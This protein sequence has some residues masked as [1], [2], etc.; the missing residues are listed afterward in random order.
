VHQHGLIKLGDPPAPDCLYGVSKVFG[1]DLGRYYSRFYGIKIVSL[2]IGW[3]TSGLI[4]EDIRHGDET[5]KNHFRV[6]HL[7]KRDLID[8]FDK[9]LN[10][11]KAY[12]VAYAVSDNHP[13]VFDLTETRQELGFYPQ[14]NAEP[15]LRGEI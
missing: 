1:E 14:D 9:A 7:S 10:V 2:R 5:M 15:Y 12:M 11:D 13:A 6:L 8:V 4:P 3:A